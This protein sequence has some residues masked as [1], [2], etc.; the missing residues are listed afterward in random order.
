[1]I[2]SRAKP[3]LQSFGVRSLALWVAFALIFA[4]ATRA[5]TDPDTGWHL[6]SAEQTLAEGIIHNDSFSHTRAGMPWVNHSWG[7]Q[8]LL[9]AAWRLAGNSGL[10]AF[11]IA[12]AMLT[13]HFVGRSAQGRGANTHLRAYLLVLGALASSVFWSARPQMFTLL[14]S[15]LTLWLLRR[16]G[17]WPWFLPA[18]LALWANLHAG[19]MLGWLWVAAWG[20]GALWDAARRGQPLK[21]KR[22]WPKIGFAGACLLAPC[23]NPYGAQIL[24]VPL[25]TLE[26]RELSAI[27]EWQSP[28]LRDPIT[29]PFLLMLALLLLAL[30]LS[31]RRVCGKEAFPLVLVLLMAL[32]AIRHIAL[33]ANVAVPILAG[34]LAA[35][36]LPASWRLPSPAR[37][38]TRRGLLHCALLAALWFGVAAYALE[39]LTP[40]KVEAELAARYPVVAVRHLRERAPAGP[41]FNAY[42]WGGYLLWELP[43]YPVFID[44]RSLLYGDEL[45]AAY[46]HAIFGEGWQALFQTHDIRLALLPRHSALERALRQQ[47]IAWERLYLDGTAAL[48]ARRET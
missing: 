46:R 33:F 39:R 42:E 15:A 37:P 35:L 44:G 10:A 1:M 31:R 23:L 28:N 36:P 25:R 22:W 9:L 13:M 8:L 7:G 16:G 45:I 19:F 18:I 30:G 21:P 32:L 47:P 3:L 14:L 43:E 48:Y 12:L 2:V 24:W 40:T 41:L 29:W 27:A 5:P 26:L 38:S 11:T 20:I 17:Y 34:Q 6:R 4:I